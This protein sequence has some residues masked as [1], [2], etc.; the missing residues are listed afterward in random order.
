MFFLLGNK[1]IEMAMAYR[2]LNF[3]LLPKILE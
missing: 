1:I 3:Y 2:N